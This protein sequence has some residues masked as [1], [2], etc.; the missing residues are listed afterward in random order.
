[1]DR[2]VSESSPSNLPYKKAVNKNKGCHARALSVLRLAHGCGGMHTFARA[3]APSTHTIDTRWT[4]PPLQHTTR[5]IR[6]ATC[7]ALLYPGYLL[8]PPHNSTF[9]P[10]TPAFA[11]EHT[12]ARDGV[13]QLSLFA[14]PLGSDRTN[15]GSPGGGHS[16]LIFTLVYG[17]YD[18][19]SSHVAHES[20]SPAR[21]ARH[22][23]SRG[24]AGRTC[25]QSA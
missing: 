19:A 8:S 20:A 6:A 16:A 10:L 3:R 15:F 1:M 11:N 5:R 17:S 4:S 23:P 12:S 13:M 21:A 2:K 18:L 7:N 25:R 9:P 14:A 22:W 24:R